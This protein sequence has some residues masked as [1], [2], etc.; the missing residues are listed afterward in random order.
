MLENVRTCLR[1][2]SLAV[3]L[4]ALPGCGASN[5]SKTASRAAAATYAGDSG[6]RLR[7]DPDRGPARRQLSDHCRRHPAR[8]ADHRRRTRTLTAVSA[9]PRPRLGPAVGP[10]QDHAELVVE[11]AEH[12]HL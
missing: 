11:R 9:D 12:E 5:G 3:V 7:H 10:E 4:A 2:A 6:A 1:V 8:G